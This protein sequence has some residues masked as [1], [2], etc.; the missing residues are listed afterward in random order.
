VISGFQ[1]NIVISETVHD[2]GE[3]TWEHKGGV[4]VTLSETVMGNSVRRPRGGDITMLSH[5][6]EK[7]IIQETMHDRGLVTRPTVYGRQTS[8]SFTIGTHRKLISLLQNPDAH[9]QRPLADN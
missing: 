9:Q 2:R 1:E 5:L 6:R 8:R 4:M 7:V 3:M